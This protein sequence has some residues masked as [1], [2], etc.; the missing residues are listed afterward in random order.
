[1]KNK[2]VVVALL[3]LTSACAAKPPEAAEKAFFKMFPTA[4]MVNWA[5]ETKTD[6]EAEFTIN[7]I[8]M[9]ANF[10]DQG[11]WLETE[12][13]ISV[14]DLPKSFTDK[15]AAENPGWKINEADK[16]EK[17]GSI[18]QYVAEIKKGVI[19]K[20]IQSGEMK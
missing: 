6:W 8:E 16:I 7:K 11:T 14:N 18:I 2:I 3:F 10:N 12:T 15:V 4:Q 9:S 19:T 5:K 17:P 13:E 1:M 20:E